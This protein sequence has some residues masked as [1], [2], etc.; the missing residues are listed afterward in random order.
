MLWTQDVLYIL[1][2]STIMYHRIT[3]RS[4][5]LR[6]SDS[7]PRPAQDHHDN[8]P[9]A[10]SQH[11]HSHPRQRSTPATNATNRDSPGAISNCGLASRTLATFH[12][13]E[14][15][16]IESAICANRSSGRCQW[17]TLVRRGMS[18]HHAL[19]SR[20]Q[21]GCRKVTMRPLL[22]LTPTPRYAH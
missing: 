12:R 14:A 16:G 11:D 1:I 3:A 9:T 13:D 21:N 17:G 5:K 19:Q 22:A 6:P 8:T 15:T 7:P 18:H 4:F 10:L 2:T 20:V